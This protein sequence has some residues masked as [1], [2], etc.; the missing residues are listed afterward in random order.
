MGGSFVP[1][2]SLFEMSETLMDVIKPVHSL[3]EIYAANSDLVWIDDSR[4][5]ILSHLKGKEGDKKTT[6]ISGLVAL[7]DAQYEVWLYQTS[8]DM[9]GRSLDSLL[10]QRSR[11]EKLLIMS[12]A[13]AANNPAQEHQERFIQANCLAHARRKFHDLLSSNESECI[14]VLKQM[15]RV[16]AVEKE[17]SEEGLDG[18]QR[19]LR[20]QEK[21]GPVLSQLKH[22]GETSLKDHSIEPNSELGKAWRYYLNHFEKLTTFLRVPGCPIDN[23]KAERELKRAILHRKNS[24]FYRYDMGALVGDVIMSLGFT[25][26]ACGLNPLAWF[27]DMIENRHSVFRNP[28]LWLPWIWKNQNRYIPWQDRDIDGLRWKDITREHLLNNKGDPSQKPAIEKV[29]A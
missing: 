10:S 26:L 13:H 3:L 8:E 24:L 7:Y 18:V 23:N 15:K 17:C 5:T 6:W 21:S 27:T 28:E 1:D 11:D 22:F 16:W 20:H 29:A 12:D 4:M 9:A 14:E 2:S 19:M 25:A